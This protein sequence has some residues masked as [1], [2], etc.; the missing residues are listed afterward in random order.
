VREVLP[1]GFDLGYQAGVAAPT[2][3]PY[4]AVTRLTVIVD[5][6]HR[7]PPIVQP[8]ANAVAPIFGHGGR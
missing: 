1:T 2:A 4:E 7:N 3:A 5:T 8:P 6:D